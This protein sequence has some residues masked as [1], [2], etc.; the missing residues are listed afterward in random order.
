MAVRDRAEGRNSGISDA[1]KQ[2]RAGNLG[3]G[4][5]A[6]LCLHGLLCLVGALGAWTPASLHPLLSLSF[7]RLQAW[8]KLQRGLRG[9]AACQTS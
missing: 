4:M 3:H 2:G 5:T 1:C 6:G 8:Q 9:A 7:G